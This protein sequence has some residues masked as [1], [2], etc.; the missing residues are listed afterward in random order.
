MRNEA[1][2]PAVDAVAELR[3]RMALPI[4]SASPKPEPVED[5]EPA[6]EPEAKKPTTAQNRKLSALFERAGLT[7]DDKA[8]RRIVFASFFPDHELGA[9]PSADETAHVI[10]QLEQIADSGEDDSVLV[11]FAEDIITQAAQS[12][13]EG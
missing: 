6:A 7:R 9:Q 1:N 11:G 13:Q 4:E 5:P 8:G 3:A 10:A 2:R 12:T